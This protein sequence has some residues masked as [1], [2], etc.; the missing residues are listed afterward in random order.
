MKT[1]GINIEVF[2]RFHG[3]DRAQVFEIAEMG[4]V[5]L[6]QQLIPEDEVET[7][8]RCLRLTND[9]G[10]NVQ[11]LDIILQMRKR[12]EEMRAELEE[13]RMLLKSEKEENFFD[14]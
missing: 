5:H 12:M 2:C 3:V 14:F 9:L 6:D 8:E 10:V 7:L 13:L 11:A 1:K 4:L